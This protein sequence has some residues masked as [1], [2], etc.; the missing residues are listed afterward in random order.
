[1]KWSMCL[2]KTVREGHVIGQG[3][4]PGHSFKGAGTAFAA[5]TGCAVIGKYMGAQTHYQTQSKKFYPTRGTAT[6]QATKTQ[7][8]KHDRKTTKRNR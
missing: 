5:T 7:K 2:I 3:L 1:M 8:E 6:A 4:I